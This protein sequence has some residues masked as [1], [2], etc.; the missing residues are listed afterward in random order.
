MFTIG[1][2]L[3]AGA[4]LGVLDCVAIAFEPRMSVMWLLV[5]T[6]LALS[7]LRINAVLADVPLLRGRLVQIGI[8]MLMAICVM[9]SMISGVGPACGGGGA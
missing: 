9:A 7:G 4:V 6:T 8:G 3:V 5:L 2:A 1:C